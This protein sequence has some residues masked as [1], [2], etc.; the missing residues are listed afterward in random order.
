MFPTGHPKVSR[1]IT[2]EEHFT[3]PGLEGSGRENPGSPMG[4][5]LARVNEQLS[6][7]GDGRLRE[8]DAAGIDLQVLSFG[9]PGVEPLEP[10]DSVSLARRVNDGLAEAIRRHPD[11]FAGLATL[12]TPAPQEAAKE[13]ERCMRQLGFKG[14][15]INGH[16]RG[17]YLDDPFFGPLLEAAEALQAPIYLHPT[18]PPEPV[19]QAYYQGHF[20]A[21]VAS[22]FSRA[23]WGWHIETATHI[24]RIILGGVFDRYPRLQFIIGHMGE[25][26]PFMLQRLDLTLPPQLTRLSQP[27]S[28]YLRQNVSY[29]FSGFNFTAAFLDLYL[30]MGAERIL[31][32]ADYPYSSM[33]QAR[34]FLENLPVSAEDRERI[35]HGNA[36][37]LLKL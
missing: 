26:L 19:F 37:R 25:T 24:L 11:R 4:A 7:L 21:E 6:D 28:H 8:M 3:L 31:F 22:Q 9:A 34:E 16:T 17:R 23:G 29:T 13:L 2:L 20:S 1:T 12:P 36:E 30:E 33:A 15:V 35:A 10:A 32:S 18:P 27:V 14:G 5:R